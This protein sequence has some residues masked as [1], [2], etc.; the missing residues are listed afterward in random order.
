MSTKKLS[1]GL[2]ELFDDFP[3]PAGVAPED[4]TAPGSAPGPAGHPGKR[5]NP[6]SPFPFSISSPGR[7]AV[8]IPA[9]GP[10]AG[11]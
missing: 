5:E 4:G 3:Y 6:A 9:G 11:R 10:G 7:L 2:V 1:I 8:N